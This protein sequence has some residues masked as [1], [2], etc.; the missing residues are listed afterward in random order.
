[1]RGVALFFGFEKLKIKGANMKELYVSVRHKTITKITSSKTDG[2]NLRYTQKG[3]ATADPEFKGLNDTTFFY[4]SKTLKN[5]VSEF[6]KANA[7]EPPKRKDAAQA[8][9]Q[10]LTFTPEF[11][12][13][14]DG[15]DWKDDRAAYLKTQQFIDF[16]KSVEDHLKKE[17]GDRLLYLAW[18]FDETTPHLH[19]MFAPVFD[20]GDGVKR[21]TVASSVKANEKTLYGGLNAEFCKNAQTSLAKSLAHFGFKRGIPKNETKRKHVKQATWAKAQEEAVKAVYSVLQG[22]E[23]TQVQKAAWVALNANPVGFLKIKDPSQRKAI[24]NLQQVQN[25]TLEELVELREQF[26]KKS[27]I[28]NKQGEAISQLKT[29]LQ[30][31][32]SE[33]KQSKETLRVYASM[34]KQLG[35]WHEPL[36]KFIE[37][38]PTFRNIFGKLVD[39][40]AE[41]K[42]ISGPDPEQ[43]TYP[44]SETTHND[45]VK[46][47]ERRAFR[48]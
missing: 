31:V 43:P 4:G 14:E 18:H 35:A 42:R 21:W 2:H 10:L 39:M 20:F 7:I 16:K 6:S 44:Q 1:M 29:S 46:P 17:H 30:D 37:K 15:S 24:Q 12:K 3:A 28:V 27:Q 40:L 36:T 48:R 26:V 22:V 8:V 41:C 13:F 32:L 11:F 25:Q 34:V 45:A 47:V 9:E 33:S 38:Y 5:A 19:A 23:P